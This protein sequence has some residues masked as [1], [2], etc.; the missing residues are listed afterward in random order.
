MDELI[1]I[2]GKE[3]VELPD[4]MLD[5]VAGGYIVCLKDLQLMC[6][7]PTYNYIAI[8]DST[9]EVLGKA[10]GKGN[11]PEK[12]AK[13]IARE[14]GQSEKEISLN[15]ANKIRKAAGLDPIKDFSSKF[16]FC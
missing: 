5:A 7:D 13:K 6:P 2:A 10:R 8:D 3:G 12:K 1:R 4:E 15:E 9:G 14:H 16:W 11:S